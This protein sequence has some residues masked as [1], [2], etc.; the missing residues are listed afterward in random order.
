M[1]KAD[2]A[3]ENAFTFLRSKLYTRDPS[4]R[5][6]Y[7]KW[8]KNLDKIPVT[9]LGSAFH[10]FHKKHGISSKRRAKIKIL[11]PSRRKVISGSKQKVSKGNRRARMNIP[12]KSMVRGKPKHDLAALVAENKAM[13]KKDSR[14]MKS[15]RKLTQKE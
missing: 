6:G 10:S 3:L 13:P 9:R 1:E 14:T 15:R 4:L 11:D 12:N 7:V 8:A 2:E 5:T